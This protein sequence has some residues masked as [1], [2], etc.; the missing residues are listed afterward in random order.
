MTR[1]I[2]DP[3]TGRC[4]TCEQ[5]NGKAHVTD[6]GEKGAQPSW[7]D[8]RKQVVYVNAFKN[9]STKAGPRP[10]GD[11][12]YL[13][14]VKS[15]PAT[16]PRDIDVDSGITTN[17][18]ASVASVS[19]VKPTYNAVAPAGVAAVGPLPGSPSPRGRDRSPSPGRWDRAR[20]NYGRNMRTT[21]AD[22]E[23]PYRVN[24]VYQWNK[25]DKETNTQVKINK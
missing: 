16:T 8:V 20:E 3:V 14:N 23:A 4:L 22:P 13:H 21:R 6:K 18:K 19:R 10:P 7:D 25:N 1:H 15:V 17:G 5:E 11:G 24:Y 9:P 2:R 12:I